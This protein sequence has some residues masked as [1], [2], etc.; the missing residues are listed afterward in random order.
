M[1]AICGF[2]LALALANLL[3]PAAVHAQTLCTVVRNPADP[4]QNYCQNPSFPTYG[5]GTSS[6]VVTNPL[7]SNP[8]AVPG[9][10][11][12]M[13]RG[14][15]N[16]FSL[17]MG[18]ALAGANLKTS[19]SIRDAFFLNY[20]TGNLFT[21]TGCPIDTGQS[22]GNSPFNAVARHYAPGDP[23]DLHVMGQYAMQLR[24][25]CTGANL[26]TCTQGDVYDGMVRVPYEIRPGMTVKV[27][28]RSPT[29]NYSWA[30]IWLFSGS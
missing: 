8:G 4:T 16:A 23:N 13:Q 26:T 19:A 15:T 25:T 11:L 28:Y 21:T 10:L 27:R 2:I 17:L 14:S 18:S 24:A 22:C 5:S 12:V 30:P 6:G 7:P 20:M 9:H 29:G 1:R 3:H